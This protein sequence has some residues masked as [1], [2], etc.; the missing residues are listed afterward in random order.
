VNATRLSILAL[1]SDA[2]AAMRSDDKITARNLLHMA[3]ARSIGHS[4][5]ASK[6]LLHAYHLSMKL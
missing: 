2:V 5:K 4:Y 6:I 1:L 3:M